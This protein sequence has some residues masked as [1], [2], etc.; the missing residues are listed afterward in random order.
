M[1]QDGRDEGIGLKVSADLG[2]VTLLDFAVSVG[3]ETSQ[4]RL[5]SLRASS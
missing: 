1:L 2:E 5:N 4:A 3:P